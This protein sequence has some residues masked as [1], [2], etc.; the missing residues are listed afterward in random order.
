MR[1]PNKR[2]ACTPFVDVGVKA[3]MVSK[4]VVG[5]EQKLALSALKVVFPDVDGNY[6][7]GDTVY[8][9]GESVKDDWGKKVYDL[10]G[11]K[12]ILVPLECVYATDAAG[13]NELVPGLSLSSHASVIKV[14]DNDL[15]L[16]T[17]G[18]D[19]DWDSEV[20]LRANNYVRERLRAVGSS[21]EVVFVTASDSP[22]VVR[23]VRD[24]SD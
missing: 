21:A 6:R 20:L 15:L 19:P 8:V 1:I 12:V 4:G 22:T 2:V 10:G 13:P 3:V 18:L 16:F 14:G 5:M 7:A 23:C 11:Q 17:V 9:L 24:A